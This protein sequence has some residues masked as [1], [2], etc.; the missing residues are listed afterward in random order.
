MFEKNNDQGIGDVVPESPIAN[1]GNMDAS[2]VLS[3]VNYADLSSSIAGTINGKDIQT[4]TV[5]APQVQKE[6]SI[7]GKFCSSVIRITTRQLVIC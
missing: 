3:D 2:R 5:F 4:H 7:V 1:M 6:L